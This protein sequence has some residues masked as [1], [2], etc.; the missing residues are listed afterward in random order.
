MESTG[1]GLVN[2]AN[3]YSYFTDKKTSFGIE[4]DS[5]VARIPLL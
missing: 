1:M 3:R 4:N 2:I 5:F